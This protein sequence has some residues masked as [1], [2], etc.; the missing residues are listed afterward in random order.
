MLR[1]C[2]LLAALSIALNSY[3]QINYVTIASGDW[4]D[5]SIWSP[6]PESGHP[7]SS[8][9]IITIGVSHEVTI[10]SDRSLTID[11]T[12]VNGTL[13]LQTASQ[14]SVV[15]GPGADLT[16]AGKFN[17]GD[18]SLVTKAMG[19]I[20][21]FLEGSLYDHRYTITAGD[22]LD[23]DWNPNSTLIISGYT[24][25]DI[26][27][28]S[29]N[30]SKPLGKVVYNC[31][32][33]TGTVD[34]AGLIHKVE[35]D[36]KVNS[37]GIA[38]V[39]L[40]T[41]QSP[42]IDI[43]GSL[44]IGGT[45]QV[46][47][48]TSGRI[49]G[50]IVSI[51]EN[52]IYT[53][54]HTTGSFTSL[55][56]ICTLNIK[57]D[58]IMN[59]P[60]GLLTTSTGYGEATFN[61]EGNFALLQG[62]LNGNVSVN[63]KQGNINF[64]GKPNMLH[65]FNNSGSIIG[66]IN[67]DV[68]TD[69]TLRVLG[70]SNVVGD[71]SSSF[72]LN[73]KL[74]LESTHVD[75]AIQIGVGQGGGN[76]RTRDRN[77]NAGATIVYNSNIAAQ[78]MGDGQPGSTGS[79]T[80]SISTLTVVDNFFGLSLNSL[81][82]T[83]RVGGTLEIKLG[84]LIISNDN[85]TVRGD[86]NIL[87]G[88]VI[89]D[90]SNPIIS[91]KTL[92]CD[93]IINLEG[94]EIHVISGNLNGDNA[95]L[96]INNDIIG[97]RYLSFSNLNCRVTIGGSGPT[98]FSRKFPVNKPLIL[99]QLTINREGVTL[100]MPQDLTVGNSANTTSGLTLTKGNL[101]MEGNLI[102]NVNTTLISGTL[103]FDDHT[104]ELR[105]QITCTPQLAPIPSGVL[106][107]NKNS[108]LKITGSYNNTT[109]YNTLLFSPQGD[110]LSYLLLDRSSMPPL[111]HITIGSPLT[112]LD[113]LGL[114]DG[115]IYNASTLNMVSGSTLVRTPNASFFRGSSVPAGILNIVY[116]DGINPSAVD[117]ATGIE[118]EGI[119]NDITTNLTG[120]VTLNSN[121]H[122]QGGFTINS[123][124]WSSGANEISVKSIVNNA[125]FKAPTTSITLV[126]DFVNNGIVDHSNGTFIFNGNSSLKGITNPLFN[127]IIISGVLKSPA[128]LNLAGNF[129]N[130]GTFNANN[131][132]VHFERSTLQ[133]ISGL[134]ITNFNNLRIS[135]AS[136]VSIET[137]QNLLGVLTLG[138]NSFIDTDG[139]LDRATFTLR[140]QNDSIALDASIATIPL[141]SSVVGNVNVERYMSGEGRIYRYLSSPVTN[142][143]VADWM[144]DFPITGDFKN[145]S[146]PSQW[147]KNICGFNLNPKNASLYCY[148]ET[149]PGS[150]TNGYITYPSKHAFSYDANLEVGRGYAPFI[151]QCSEA[152]RVDVK[153]IVNQATLS[154]PVTYT[155]TVND[156]LSSIGW[157]L[158]GNPYPSAIDWNRVGDLNGNGSSVDVVDGWT[159]N[160]IAAA[161]AIR[162]NGAGV[163]RYWDGD[164]DEDQSS[165]PKGLIASGQGFWVRATGAEPSLIIREGVKTSS[166][167]SFFRKASIAA[168]I[169]S[170]TKNG[171]EDKA[172]IKIRED[173]ASELDYWDAPKINNDF[174]NVS[175]VSGDNIPM[176]I[177]ALANVDCGS[178]INLSMTNLTNG[179]YTMKVH[180]RS[181]FGWYGLDLHDKYL[182]V[183]RSINWE[184]SFEFEVNDEMASRAA[185]RF[186][187]RLYDMEPENIIAKLPLS[188]CHDDAYV[189]IVNSQDNIT[190]S[191][192]SEGVKLSSTCVKK[193]DS[194]ILIL[195]K[196]QLAQGL[197]TIV[198][199]GQNL[200][201]SIVESS[202]LSLFYESP[203]L[204]QVASTLICKEGS[205]KLSASPTIANGTIE[206]FEHLDDTKPISVGST[207]ET[208][209]L[210]ESKMYYASVITDLGCSSDR[211]GINAIVVEFEN[212]LITIEENN[213]KCNYSENLQW[214]LNGLILPL[215][216]NQQLN[217]QSAGL[218]SVKVII[219]GCEA[220]AGIDYTIN[221][222]EKRVDQDLKVFP[223]PIHDKLSLSTPMK[224][225]IR[226][227]VLINSVGVR[228][229]LSRISSK[230][231]CKEFDTSEMPN[232]FY[233]LEIEA[234]NGNKKVIRIIKMA[235]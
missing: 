38:S 29:V 32:S 154:L 78:V 73:G 166:T 204:T 64:T 189:T 209:V 114:I 217:A 105:R 87:G 136:G 134:A 57:G 137:D 123:G 103:F 18:L 118:A 235:K 178:L 208:P 109:N 52:F 231:D 150:A 113:S 160:K 14:I 168:M 142:A 157:N 3:S 13:T 143:T 80:T 227:A 24:T 65:T 96:A 223:N 62:T 85:L 26:I 40:S 172:Y 59:A 92:R 34:F 102:V 230:P 199:K 68:L 69:Q 47:L 139:S 179:L 127:N 220:S 122:S 49:P 176:A 153:G 63:N 84:D 5:P 115:E 221:Y 224:N 101:S 71:S 93:G 90:T 170:L 104:V 222:N 188:V 131:G 91:A 226:N 135:N 218:Y 193:N 211:V 66:D 70:E 41:N 173:A 181:G 128:V 51:G 215:E 4:D 234:D 45:S 228:L 229:E 42:V 97:T 185:D 39:R 207:Y 61:L 36:L 225:D 33:Q 81:A 130:N 37:T 183:S 77:Y 147:P 151:R 99:E 152:T 132:E 110:S 177:N 53:S 119:L 15:D 116:K 158:V 89:I 83:V 55:T 58:F 88:D 133:T 74:I 19:S 175:V 98:N 149:K 186:T 163:V 216:T 214:Y 233:A 198:I 27:F 164:P 167:A 10:P 72:T 56:G 165:I 203:T 86:L 121:I 187:I 197:N 60:Q 124:S 148:D 95:T 17:R 25:S 190:Y 180:N 144:D 155:N 129:I 171:R 50:S 8:D 202:P 195:P 100:L 161:I 117:L 67:Y 76:I 156:S 44:V 20:I 126:E 82:S 146:L 108:N 169:I 7:N 6:K 54:T 22:L 196:T 192:W 11:Q 112:I 28:S 184:E 191:A 194:L 159:K 182:K 111:P 145:P 23:A 43:A 210:K 46:Y 21:S 12:V 138:T 201:G 94:G 219:K 30:W 212:L 35:G 2:V 1:S 125:T 200:C 106:S 206:W 174:H 16:V 107:G 48:S 141:S 232:G 120:T 205:S 162:D 31:Q 75:G 9:G 140:S 213:L 79:G